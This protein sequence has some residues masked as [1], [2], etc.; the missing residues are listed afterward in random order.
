MMRDD[1]RAGDWIEE[2]MHD[3]APR[4]GLILEVLGG[5][6]HRHY[7]VRWDEDHVAIHFPSDSAR[8]IRSAEL[9]GDRSAGST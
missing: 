8:I 3:G 6:S 2:R 1:A 5:P 4:R 9:H 7:R